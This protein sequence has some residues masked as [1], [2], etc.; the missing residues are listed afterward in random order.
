MRIVSNAGFTEEL[1]RD[2]VVYR[3]SIEIAELAGRI[4]GEHGVSRTFTRKRRVAS[5]SLSTIC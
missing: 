3:V 2:M 4:E 1:K 5:P